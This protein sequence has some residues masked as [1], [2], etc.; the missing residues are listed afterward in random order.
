MAKLSGPG[1]VISWVLWAIILIP[2]AVVLIYVGVAIAD[3]YGFG[4]DAL[5]CKSTL[6]EVISAT[7]GVTRVDVDCRE[8]PTYATQSIVVHVAASD[9]LGV[10]DTATQ[11][12]RR[13][14]MDPRVEDSWHLP[15]DYRGADGRSWG[16][17]SES[18]GLES[19]VTVRDVRRLWGIEPK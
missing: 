19:F 6:Q 15:E 16:S 1:K 14:A 17:L 2:V 18:L 9:E 5:G 11:V 12:L 10:R 13:L 7:P 3:G 8:Y 4:P